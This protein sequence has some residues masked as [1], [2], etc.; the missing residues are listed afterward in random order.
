MNIIGQF[1][2]KKTSNGNLVGEWSNNDQNKVFSESCDLITAGND[3][4]VGEYNSTWQE[5]GEAIFAKLTITRK[6]NNSPL[7]SLKW[8]GKGF[9]FEGDG[10]LC[11]DVLMGRF[12][13]I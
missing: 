11:D 8:Q 9:G 2:L 6:T 12:Q 1:Y 13:E 3:S 4:Y 10:M 5:K 7:F